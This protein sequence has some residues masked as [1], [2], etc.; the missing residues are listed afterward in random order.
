MIP[1]RLRLEFTGEHV[2]ETVEYRGWK[3]VVNGAIL[4]LA[5]AAGYDCLVTRDRG[6]PAQQNLPALGISVVVVRPR[7]QDLDDWREMVPG[8]EQELRTIRPGEIRR[9]E[10]PS[11]GTP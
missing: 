8:I 4:P 7:G 6:I 11:P 2:V 1:V 9:I 10:A 5:R 3:G